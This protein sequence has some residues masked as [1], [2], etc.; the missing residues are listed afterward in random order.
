MRFL[1]FFCSSP[2]LLPSRSGKINLELREKTAF[3]NRYLWALPDDRFYGTSE[4]SNCTE[5]LK[6]ESLPSTVTAKITICSVP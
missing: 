3:E 5:I 1:P 6:V 4:V 2:K